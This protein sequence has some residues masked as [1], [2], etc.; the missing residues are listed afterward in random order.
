MRSGR[1][2]ALAL[3]GLGA[4]IVLVACGGG[5]HKAMTAPF[6][7]TV[8]EKKT[9]GSNTVEAID[10]TAYDGTKV[11]ALF[12]YPSDSLACLMYQGGIGQPKEA[13]F[14]PNGLAAGAAKLRLSTF[15]IDPRDTG[16]RGST[17]L[18]EQDVQNPRAIRAVIVD[19]VND[20]RRGLTYLEAQPQ[21]HDR[22]GYLGTSFGGVLGALLAGSDPRIGA[23]VLTSIGATWQEA[24][25]VPNTPLLP[26]DSHDP[27]ALA[28]ALTI[29]E[30]YSADAWVGKI[31]PRPV[32]L[33]N[34]T[35][36]PYVPQIDAA[37]LAKHIGEP[38][39]IVMFNGGHNPF[40]APGTSPAQAA[41]NAQRVASFL[42]KNLLGGR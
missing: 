16:A 24:L 2:A 5:G 31:A 20:L 42:V 6:H 27:K 15:S 26:Q 33:L 40:G 21:C 23:V 35:N 1:N 9:F 18:L 10:Y 36:D 32:M 39:V 34:G 41:A 29:L 3:L 38:K 11:P 28:S 12:A 17:A 25:S 37:D 8:V 14:Q 22:V 30:P 4:S 7:A 13:A 19:T